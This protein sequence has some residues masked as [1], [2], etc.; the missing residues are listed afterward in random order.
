MPVPCGEQSKRSKLTEV[1]VLRIRR[2]KKMGVTN[3]RLSRDYSVTVMCI[4]A[5]VLR[6]TWKHVPEADLTP[7]A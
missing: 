4:R 2:L 1:Q 6:Q 3:A 7:D 5:I